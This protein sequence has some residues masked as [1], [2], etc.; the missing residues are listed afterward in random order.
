M[1]SF[2]NFGTGLGIAENLINLEFAP[3]RVRMG[4]RVT[5]EIL[6]PGSI[7]LD[8]SLEELHSQGSDIPTHPVESGAD[9]TDHIRRK[10]NRLRIKGLVTNHPAF[11][12]GVLGA[13]LVQGLPVSL[14]RA[15]EYF[16]AL[17]ALKNEGQIIAVI[18]TLKT[19]ENMVIKDFTVPRNAKL[20]NSVEATILLEEIIIVATDETSKPA[21]ADPVNGGTVAGGRAAPPP[22]AAAATAAKSTSVLS[23]F[24][25]G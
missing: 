21:P 14:H 16:K 15:E 3:R 7:E 12:G 19:Y 17:E 13:A 22:A 8:A 6:A 9:I 5:A 11:L 25:G 2:L 10:P 20:G 24:F 23:A 1:S 18:T 4:S